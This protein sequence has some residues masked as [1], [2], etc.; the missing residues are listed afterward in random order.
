MELQFWGYEV[1]N[2][3]ATIAGAGGFLSFYNIIQTVTDEQSSGAL[4]VSFQLLTLYPDASVTLGLGALV[5]VVPALRASVFSKWHSQSLNAI[6]LMT[7]IVALSILC[8]SIL[9]ETSWIAIAGSFFV[10]ASCLLRQCHGNPVLLKIGGLALACGGIGLAAYGLQTALSAVATEENR[11]VLMGVL[12]LVTGFYV[13]F[14]GLLTYEGGIFAI[15]SISKQD[16]DCAD[17]VWLA[18]LI[19]PINGL[20]ARCVLHYTDKPIMDMNERI[21][22][23]AI[24]WVSDDTRDNRPFKTS[25]LARLPWRL[26]TGVAALFSLTPAG[27]AFF[28][29]NVCWAIGDVAIGSEDW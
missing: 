28:T 26:F 12:T 22:K 14:A 8:Y 24:F 15:E 16:I 29:A 2:V 23:P 17:G 25:M 7:T 19:H 11:S 10:L 13:F 27:F 1:G 5:L 9:L 18:R 20:L 3:L 4:A 6:D 21:S